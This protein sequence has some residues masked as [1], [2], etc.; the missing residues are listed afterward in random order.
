VRPHEWAEDPKIPDGM[1]GYRSMRCSVCGRTGYLLH[2]ERRDGSLEVGAEPIH[3][4]FEGVVGSSRVPVRDFTPD[5]KDCD[6]ERVRQVQ[7]S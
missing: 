4:S 6:M 7:E 2:G 5:E 3:A 1:G